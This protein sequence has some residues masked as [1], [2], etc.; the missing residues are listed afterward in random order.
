MGPH[1][2]TSGGEDR[3]GIAP[4]QLSILIIIIGFLLM[5]SG[6]YITNEV[7]S[8]YFSIGMVIVII[9]ACFFGLFIWARVYSMSH[10]PVPIPAFVRDMLESGVIR[11]QP[12]QTQPQRVFNPRPTYQTSSTVGTQPMG[13]SSPG[14]YP[15]TPV[16]QP[17]T[18]PT[19]MFTA[20]APQP[21]AQPFPQQTVSQSQPAMT[22][23][24]DVP[25]QPAVAPASVPQ[26]ASQPVV[27]PFLPQ[28]GPSAP[29][30]QPDPEKKKEQY[31][32][33]LEEADREFESYI[34]KLIEE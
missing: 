25:V 27:K 23:S 30:Q 18:Q 32:D 24:A 10:L 11:P 6:I 2:D 8:T 3:N 31:V 17:A 29:K 22:R 34:D 14:A 1:D 7:F 9:G 26:P 12:A 15:T 4:E 33:V 28:S 19:P 5:I 21:V 16:Q 20:P 13:Q